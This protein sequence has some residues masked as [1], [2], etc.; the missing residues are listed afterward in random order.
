MYGYASNLHNII[1]TI[2]FECLP[3]ILQ[4]IKYRTGRSSFPTDG[5]WSCAPAASQFINVL[6][7]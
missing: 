2:K 4:N 5:G 6:K 3:I 7:I 1:I